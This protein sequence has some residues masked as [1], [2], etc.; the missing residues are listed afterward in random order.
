MIRYCNRLTV[1]VFLFHTIC[2]E[3]SRAFRGGKRDIVLLLTRGTRL[4]VDNLLMSQLRSERVLLFP[5][6]RFLGL[7]GALNATVRSSMI[8]GLAFPDLTGIANFAAA[9]I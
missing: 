9:Y 6:H 1:F 7:D 4:V 8:D 2:I 5:N 3:D